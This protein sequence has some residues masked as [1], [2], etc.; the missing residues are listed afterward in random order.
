MAYSKTTSKMK[1]PSAKD[2]VQIYRSSP[3]AFQDKL[4]FVKIWLRERNFEEEVQENQDILIWKM[5][6]HMSARDLPDTMGTLGVRYKIHPS[7]FQLIHDWEEVNKQICLADE[8]DGWTQ[9]EADALLTMIHY[10]AVTLRRIEVLDDLSKAFAVPVPTG[11]KRKVAQ[12]IQLY[13]DGKANPSFPIEESWDGRE[14]LS[15]AMDFCDLMGY[16][17]PEIEHNKNLIRKYYSLVAKYP[18]WAE[19]EDHAAVCLDE[20]GP[21]DVPGLD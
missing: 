20:N 16:S 17:W 2:A 19:V 21:G 11:F 1:T 9:E 12:D 15:D 14:Y 10:K 4:R 6:E 8:A 7:D 18:R 3:R 13:L 5:A